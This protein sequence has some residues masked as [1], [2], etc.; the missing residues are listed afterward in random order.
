M[1]KLL[2]GCSLL[3]FGMPAANAAD[4]PARPYY[5]AP[6]VAYLP[7]NRCY[8]GLTAGYTK[9]QTTPS[10]TTTDPNLAQS[11]TLGNVNP[12]P[13]ESPDG[14][15]V[16]PTVGCNW[17][18]G[19]TVYGLET[20]LSYMSPRSRFASVQ[21]PALVT[22]LGEQKTNVLGTLRGR[23]GIASQNTLFYATGGLAYGHVE[24][25]FRII[26]PA[27]GPAELAAGEDKWKVGWT[28]GAGIEH[29][30]NQNWSVKAEYLY[31]NLGSSNLALVTVAGAPPETGV[32]SYKNAGHIV[33]A[34]LNYH[35]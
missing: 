29:L 10:I 24:S 8:V 21:G 31:Y 25:S 13:G 22:N 26:P 14:A 15:I 9:S 23:L 35:F 3:A 19:P 6:P 34:G 17:Q 12:T 16:G 27:P 33:R 20:D 5:K 28:V 2:L 30:F 1:K 18:S 4:L 7:W 11:L 32:V